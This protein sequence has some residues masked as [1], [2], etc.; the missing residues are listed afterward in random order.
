M[1]ISLKNRIRDRL[2]EVGIWVHK[3]KIEARAKE[4]GYLAETVN[5]RCREMVSGKLSNGG[6]CKIELEE[7]KENGSTLYRYLPQETTI[8][9]PIR[10]ENGVIL[11]QE[12]IWK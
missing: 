5:R 4:W 11:K 10:T 3:G 2:R 8:T 12:T 9:V 7:K 1:K 6:T